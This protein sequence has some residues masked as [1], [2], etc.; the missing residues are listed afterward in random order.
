MFGVNVLRIDFFVLV[1]T[2][3]TSNKEKIKKKKNL[4]DKL[5]NYL[6]IEV[7]FGVFQLVLRWF[8]S[9]DECGGI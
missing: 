7:V 2:H 8:N 1:Q 5:K 6:S 4:E 3:S 9:R